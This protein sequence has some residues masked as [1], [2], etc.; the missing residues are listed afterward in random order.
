MGNGKLGCI[1]IEFVYSNALTIM[2]KR[3]EVTKFFMDK[4]IKEIDIV[5]RLRKE[6]GER[7]MLKAKCTNEL[8]K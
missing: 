1:L 6:Y 5:C 2:W 3:H 4:D 7:L 8:Q